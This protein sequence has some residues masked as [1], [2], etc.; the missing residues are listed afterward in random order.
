MGASCYLSSGSKG[1]NISLSLQKHVKQEV[2]PPD[3]SFS[4]S[5][6]LFPSGSK[7]GLNVFG[8]LA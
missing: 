6:A 8:L 1:K 4:G 2:G 5:G 7:L 3:Y